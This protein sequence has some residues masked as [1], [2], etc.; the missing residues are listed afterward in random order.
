MW[1]DF[2]EEKFDYEWTKLRD[3]EHWIKTG[4]ISLGQGDGGEES[5]PSI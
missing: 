2:L 1:R 3:Y 4:L 5:S